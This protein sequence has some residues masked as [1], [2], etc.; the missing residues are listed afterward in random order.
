MYTR[1]S[2]SRKTTMA[3]VVLKAIA[4]CAA[5]VFCTLPSDCRDWNAIFWKFLVHWQHRLTGM[6]S[7]SHKRW[8]NSIRYVLEK[9]AILRWNDPL[10]VVLVA[11]PRKKPCVVTNVCDP[12]THRIDNQRR[13]FRGLSVTRDRWM[14]AG[15]VA[16]CLADM[17]SKIPRT[18]D[19]EYTK[20]TWNATHDSSKMAFTIRYSESSCRNVVWAMKCVWLLGTWD[21]IDDAE[22]KST[23]RFSQRLTLQPGKQ[24]LIAVHFWK[25]NLLYLKNECELKTENT[26][27][28]ETTV[29]IRKELFSSKKRS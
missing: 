26:S 10:S 17:G 27:T 22:D 7:I 3:S 2:A 18:C 14:L 21:G 5:M 20:P 8:L 11:R 28:T 13:L 15:Y 23:R 25:Q 19:E 6:T 9:I 24:L 16:G 12:K 1:F 29:G 4:L